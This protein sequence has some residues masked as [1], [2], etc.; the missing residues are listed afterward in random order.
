MPVAGQALEAGALE[1]H[2]P[3]QVARRVQ[4][5]GDA[6]GRCRT[7]RRLGVGSVA[8]D[9]AEV[10]GAEVRLAAAD[11]RFD[12]VGAGGQ[13]RHPYGGRAVGRDRDGAQ[14]LGVLKDGDRVASRASGQGGGGLGHGLHAEHGGQEQGAVQEVVGEVGVGGGGQVGVG[15]EFDAAGVGL[16]SVDEPQQR[17]FALLEGDGG[18]AGAAHDDQGV[19]QVGVGQYAAEHRDALVGRDRFDA[20]PDQ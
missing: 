16:D 10:V 4:C 17:Q 2:R 6:F 15:D 7:L 13:D 9:G 8:Q 1:E 5:R 12:G 18:Q 11:D 3:V 20:L 19:G 14:E